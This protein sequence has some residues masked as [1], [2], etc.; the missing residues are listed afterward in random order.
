MTDLF[1]ALDAGNSKTVAVVTDERG[2]VR[3]LGRGGRGD[4]YNAASPDD[5]VAAVFGAADAAL[6]EADAS[7]ARVVWAAFRVAGVDWP[8]DERW[9]AERI[10]Q[11]YPGLGGFSVKNDGF[12]SLRLGSP[13]GT[14]V[15]ITVGTGPAI[16]ARAADGAEACTGW[17]VFDDLGGFGIANRAFEAVSR[18]W[19]GLGPQTAL[20]AELLGLFE[21]GEV[22]DLHHSFTRRFG[23]REWAERLR[24]TRSVLRLAADGDSVALR[25]VVDQADALVGY[26]E[27]VARQVSAEPGEAVPI[28][29]NGSIVTSETPVLRLALT[30]RLEQRFPGCPIRVA[31]AS[32]LTGCVLDALAEGGVL[33]SEAERDAVIATRYPDGFLA[34]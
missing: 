34:T 16:A 25:I 23:A 1:L 2:A 28:V 9:W 5:A 10:A 19:M 29:L 18:A 27:W 14:G 20:T 26:A 11:R 12:A 33:L 4:I 21:E 6:A 24:A 13:D 17:W 8:E 22:Y 32:P 31:A 7:G 15:G 30:E 3:G